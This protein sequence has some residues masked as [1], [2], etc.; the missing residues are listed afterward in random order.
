[1]FNE[2][3]AGGSNFEG[4]A[5]DFVTMGSIETHLCAASLKASTQNTGNDE[6]R[7]VGIGPMDVS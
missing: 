2:S 6:S 7:D 5:R 1:M 4:L 3:L